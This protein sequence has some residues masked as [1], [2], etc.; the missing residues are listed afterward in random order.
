MPRC[1]KHTHL[2]TTGSE[3]MPTKLDYFWR[4]HTFTLCLCFH[5]DSRYFLWTR[6]FRVQGSTKFEITF[7]ITNILDSIIQDAIL[8]TADFFWLFLIILQVL[9]VVSKSRL[10]RTVSCC[11]SHSGVL[12]KE[13]QACGCVDWEKLVLM[14]NNEV[15]DE[16]EQL[17]QTILFPGSPLHP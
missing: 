13:R 3:A 5:S 17:S 14:L 12:D 8:H 11:G 2:A 15:E 10:F 4:N 7:G 1:G 9:T 6:H 16:M